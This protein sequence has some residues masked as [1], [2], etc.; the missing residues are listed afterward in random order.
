[1]A[2]KKLRIKVETEALITERE[3]ILLK[4][5]KDEIDRQVLVDISKRLHE[6]SDDLKKHL[7]EPI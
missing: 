4:E 1:M 6:I 5:E 7:G 2:V 3:L